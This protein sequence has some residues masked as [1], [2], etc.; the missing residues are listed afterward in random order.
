MEKFD[1]I[2]A[3]PTALN[4]QPS[5]LMIPFSGIQ[6]QSEWVSHKWADWSTRFP[7]DF[8]H[9]HCSIY[10]FLLKSTKLNISPIPV[11][12]MAQFDQIIS[13]PTALNPQSSRLLI[14]FNQLKMQSEWVTHKWAT[15]SNRSPTLNL[16]S[17]HSFSSKTT[18]F[19]FSTSQI[20]SAPV[21]HRKLSTRS[22]SQPK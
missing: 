1:Q 5:R 7:I 4:P 8:L 21:N 14:P 19:N 2:I 3:N 18:N 9:S 13:N 12:S 20:P 6:M 15:W 22:D 17:S 10:S 11:D 16:P